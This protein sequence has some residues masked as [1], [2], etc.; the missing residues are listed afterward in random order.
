[1]V[2]I[3]QF[4]IKSHLFFLFKIQIKFKGFH[5]QIYFNLIKESIK[6]III[7]DFSYHFYYFI[8]IKKFVA[9]WILLFQLHPNSVI[10][11]QN[12]LIKISLYLF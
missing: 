1:M 9:I 12:I 8:T 2:I 3:K 11:F 7:V 5:E 10:L 4:L 6:K